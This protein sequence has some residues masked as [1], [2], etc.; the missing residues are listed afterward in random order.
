MGMMRG[1]PIYLVTC[2]LAAGCGG[3]GDD[4]GD[5]DGADGA[6]SVGGSVV[7][8]VTGEAIDGSLSISTF[9]LDPAPSISTSGNEFTLDN[10]TPHSIF[11]VLA[12]APPSYRATYGD[13]IEVEESDRAGVEIA[14]VS[15]EYLAALVEAFAV[16]PSASAG[17]LFA[18][19]VGENG[20]GRAGVP[21]AAFESPPGAIGPFFLDAELQPAPEATETSASGWVLWFEVPAGVVGLTA[22]AG[23]GYTMEMATSPVAPAAATVA[24]LRVTDGESALP[25]NVSFSQQV[26]PIFELRGCQNCHSGSGPGRDLGNLTLDGSSNLI[27]RELAEEGAFSVAGQRVNL[28][29]PEESLVLTMPSAEDP[30]DPHPNITFTGPLDPDYLTILV[31]IREGAKQN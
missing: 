28:Q 29:S 6:L 16:D 11:N 22:D 19:A 9:G 2:I 21:A 23:S 27:Y 1:K 25:Q 17:V 20:Q 5:D 10:V 15:E 18:H 3:G 7:D 4:G 13:A 24:T 14:A 31:W 12:G 26:L 30:A 8:F